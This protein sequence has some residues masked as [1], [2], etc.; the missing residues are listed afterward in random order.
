MSDKVDSYRKYELDFTFDKIAPGTGASILELGGGN[1]LQAHLLSLKGYTV[2]SIDT[3]KWR[4][5]KQYFDV[6]LYDGIHIPAKDQSFDIIYS[7]NVLEH[8]ADLEGLLLDCRRVLKPTGLAV[9]V[10]PSSAWRF[11]SILTH[12]IFVFRRMRAL[13]RKARPEIDEP[14]DNAMT[15]ERRGRIWMIKNALVPPAHG[16]FSSCVAELYQYSKSAWRRR[17]YKMNWEVTDCRPISLLYTDS[18]ALGRRLSIADRE[19][20]SRF[21]GPACNLFITRRT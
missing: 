9:H 19:K 17:F 11:W 21:L 15:Y 2:Q 6:A 7:S 20:I 18:S 16:E 5:A 10:L 14:S 4:E 13:F 12:Y 1:G 8:V 3:V